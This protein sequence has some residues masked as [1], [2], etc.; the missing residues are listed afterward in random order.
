MSSLTL[1]VFT[2]TIALSGLLLGPHLATPLP[3]SRAKARVATIYVHPVLEPMAETGSRSQDDLRLQ[4][5]VKVRDG[6]KLRWV[7]DLV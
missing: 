3:W 4:G 7:L 2:H 1:R 5:D 6:A